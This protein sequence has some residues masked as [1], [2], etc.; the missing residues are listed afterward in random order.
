MSMIHRDNFQWK[1][2]MPNIKKRIQFVLKIEQEKKNS[3]SF[4]LDHH[5]GAMDVFPRGKQSS[6]SGAHQTHL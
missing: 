3:G 4:F 6:D 2:H 5:L 1:F